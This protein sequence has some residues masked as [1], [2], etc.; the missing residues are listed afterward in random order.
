MRRP[1]LGSLALAW[2]ALGPAPTSATDAPALVV[3]AASDLAFAF[4][5]IAPRFE[6]AE[7]VRVALVF[8]STGA[9]AHQIRHGAPADVFFAADRS[10]VDA[11]VA[12]GVLLPETRTL[13]ARGRIVLATA[14]AFGR[15]LTELGEL[16]D[17]RIR[18]VAIANPAHAPYGRAAEQALRR[19]GAWETVRPKLVYGENVRHVL[20]FVQTGAAE[21]GIVALSIAD[22]PEIVWAPIDPRLHE[23]LDQA[24]AVVRRSPRPGLGLAFIR[25]VNSSEGRSVMR[26]HGFALPG[27]F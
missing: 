16:T 14:R 18:H 2:L 23:P 22:V 6:R 9:F 11:L 20:Q 13:Y 17:S 21:A 24:A 3:F 1:L 15:R 8:G 25:F 12:E 26:R 10:F 5:E 7:G 27:E 4:R 19:A